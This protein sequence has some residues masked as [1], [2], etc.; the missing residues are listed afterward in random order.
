MPLSL[1]RQAT[2][3]GAVMHARAVRERLAATRDAPD[4]RHLLFLRVLKP[5]SPADRHSRSG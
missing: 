5:F 3:A 1:G 2:I 4:V